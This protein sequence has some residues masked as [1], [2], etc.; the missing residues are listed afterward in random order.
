M[1]VW[2]PHVQNICNIWMLVAMLVSIAC[3][4]VAVRLNYRLTSI[5]DWDVAV[6]QISNH[7]YVVYKVCVN[8]KTLDTDQATV[9]YL[10]FLISRGTMIVLRVFGV[11][12][13]I[14]HTNIRQSS[15]LS[16]Y[17]ASRV[18]C[19]I[20]IFDC[21]CHVSFVGISHCQDRFLSIDS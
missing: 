12:L 16:R 15:L 2:L 20:I 10:S 6:K 1:T 18:Q 8:Q 19:F 11:C 14:L 17:A 4:F 13:H 3:V 7:S 21:I 5:R 9:I